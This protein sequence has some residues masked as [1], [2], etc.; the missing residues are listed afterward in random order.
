MYYIKEW[1]MDNVQ[2]CDIYIL[3]HHRHKPKDLSKL[4][5]NLRRI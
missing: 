4:D 5:Q 2:N 3:I 1:A